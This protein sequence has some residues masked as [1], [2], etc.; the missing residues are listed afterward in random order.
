MQLV[1][2]SQITMP[3]LP[4]NYSEKL[5][6][7]YLADVSELRH[8]HFTTFR[9]RHCAQDDVTKEAPVHNSVQVHW[10]IVYSESVTSAAWKWAAVQRL[11]ARSRWSLL[12]VVVHQQQCDV[13]ERPSWRVMLVMPSCCS[14]VAS[15]EVD[16]GQLSRLFLRCRPQMICV[17]FI[18]LLQAVNGN[19]Q[20]STELLWTALVDII[21]TLRWAQSRATRVAGI[22]HDVYKRLTYAN[23]LY[24]YVSDG[25]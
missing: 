17:L 23:I 7:S 8:S 9:I 25:H 22:F 14:A 2:H 15:L 19:G 1:K 18:R 21:G 13:N 16:L 12:L 10:L 3:H 6:N 24:I 5:I 20:Y 11:T 4:H